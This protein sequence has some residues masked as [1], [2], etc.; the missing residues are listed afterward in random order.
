M[1]HAMTVLPRR[2][3]ASSVALEYATLPANVFPH[4]VLDGFMISDRLIPRPCN[5]RHRSSNICRITKLATNQQ[6]MH[7]DTSDVQH[8][9]RPEQVASAQAGAPGQQ[10]TPR[11][12]VYGSERRTDV[13]QSHNVQRTAA[14]SSTDAKHHLPTL[15]PDDQLAGKEASQQPPGHSGTSLHQSLG[16]HSIKDD[17]SLAEQVQLVAI[18]SQLRTLQYI[19]SCTQMNR[20]LFV[21]DNF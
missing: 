7:N 6:Q 11:Q 12:A 13:Q 15:H 2:M 8:L 20:C 1:H 21:V 17:H 19:S 16:H 10:G 4:Q 9:E 3:S 5:V 18:L 14:A